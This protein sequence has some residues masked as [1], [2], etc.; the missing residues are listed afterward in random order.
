M[1]ALRLHAF[2][3]SLQCGVVWCGAIMFQD[4][5][6][7]PRKH[8]PSVVQIARRVTLDMGRRSVFAVACLEV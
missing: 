4:A 6:A 2:V 5:G 7:A 1:H 3:R 8:V